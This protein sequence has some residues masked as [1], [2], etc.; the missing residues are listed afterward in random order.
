MI[1]VREEWKCTEMTAEVSGRGKHTLPTP[2]E[3]G[4][5]QGD[6]DAVYIITN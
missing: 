5:R 3:M 1:W 6:D 2:H 4:Q